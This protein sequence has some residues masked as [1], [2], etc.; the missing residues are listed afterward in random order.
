M[1]EGILVLTRIIGDTQ[2]SEHRRRRDNVLVLKHLNQFGQ[3]LSGESQ[4][5]HTA[6]NLDVDGETMNA[7]FK[8]FL[9]QVTPH[10][11]VIKLGFQ[12][13]LEHRLIVHAIGVEHNNRHGDACLAQV[14]ALVMHSDSKVVA[15]AVLKR[16]G[17]LVTA[18]A[19][20]TGL[21]HA[22]RLGTGLDERFEELEIVSQ[23]VQVHFHDCHVL[24]GFEQVDDLAEAETRIA[25]DE[26]GLIVKIA[27]GDIVKELLCV[28]KETGMRQ[29]VEITA[30]ASHFPAYSHQAVHTLGFQQL[31]HADIQ[32][33]AA[34]TLGSQVAQDDRAGSVSRPTRH[35]VERWRE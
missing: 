8:A 31:T 15:A 28:L 30:V 13:I 9:N 26:D 1:A 29:I 7:I 24:F 14:H 33:V 32:L 22:H 27:L 10:I 3:L 19:I 34:I 5:M 2:V 11:H 35:E 4:A 16:F 21:N 23:S 20:T 12:S 6:V 17:N 18:S 25:L